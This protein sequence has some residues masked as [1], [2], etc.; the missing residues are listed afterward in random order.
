MSTAAGALVSA[1]AVAAFG[2][3]A[4]AAAADASGESG[5][6]AVVGVAGVEV[7]GGVGRS[8]NAEGSTPTALDTIAG[9]PAA[10]AGVPSL[11]DVG[12]TPT[13]LET[14]VGVGAFGIAAAE[15]ADA[16]GAGGV[17]LRL[18]FT[19]GTR[20]VRVPWCFS[21]CAGAIACVACRRVAAGALKTRGG[22]AA[23]VCGALAGTAAGTRS[24]GN[25]R[26]GT[27]SACRE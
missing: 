10:A 1:A 12:S 3:S 13:E 5:V 22:A 26:D 20:I 4:I 27:L 11:N 24:A 2:S 16:A 25:R 21:G 15:D 8:R 18:S 9:V 7:A 17:T 19:T 14:T 23:F 6:G